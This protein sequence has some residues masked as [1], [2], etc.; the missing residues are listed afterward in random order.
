MS[1]YLRDLASQVSMKSMADPNSGNTATLTTSGVD[2]IGPDGNCFG[3]Q[4]IGAVTGTTPTWAGKFQE[5][6]D[7]GVLDTFTDVVGGAFPQV[8]A[9]GVSMITFQ[10]QKRWLRYVGTIG[11]TS[12]PTFPTQILLAEPHKTVGSL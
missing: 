11:G 10:R 8:T 3:I 9:A 12:T 4:V 2:M 1:T 6:T 5:S 7:N